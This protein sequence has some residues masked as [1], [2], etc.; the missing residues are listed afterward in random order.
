MRIII[1]VLPI[2]GMAVNSA[3]A[4]ST[5]NVSMHQV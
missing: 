1:S 2:Q 4:L 5:M 3:A